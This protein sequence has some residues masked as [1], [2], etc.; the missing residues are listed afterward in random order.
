MKRF[1]KA[2]LVTRNGAS[3]AQER[4]ESDVASAKRPHA[5]KRSRDG[6][7]LA[8]KT[9]SSQADQLIPITVV[10]HLLEFEACKS[11]FG[12]FHRSYGLEPPSKTLDAHDG[13]S[14]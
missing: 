9:G 3:Q 8:I 13:Q 1:R 2:S 7:R 14:R 4:E 10:A 11:S 5:V 12:I 6:E